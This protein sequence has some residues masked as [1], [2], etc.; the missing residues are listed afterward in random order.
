MPLRA[1][2]IAIAEPIPPDIY[3]L[4][5][6]LLDDRPDAP[7][8]N[9]FLPL[10]ISIIIEILSLFYNPSVRRRSRV[11]WAGGD[12]VETDLSETRQNA[13]QRTNKF[14]FKVFELEHFCS[15]G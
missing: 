13:S 12:S 3:F 4:L 14:L 10:M 2:A 5:L 1:K 8:I 7:V 9:A 11:K 15:P 6:K